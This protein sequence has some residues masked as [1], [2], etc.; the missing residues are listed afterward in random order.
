MIRFQKQKKIF[1]N[2][3]IAFF[4]F[5]ALI[6][7][8]FIVKEDSRNTKQIQ[9]HATIIA[10]NVWNLNH[11][12]IQAYLILALHADYYQ[13][14]KI[15][16]DQD[17]LFLE[18]SKPDST[19]F[20]AF[21]R[22]LHLIWNK[23]IEAAIIY[24]GE[25]IGVLKAEKIVRI[26]YTLVNIFVFQF[27]I[28]ITGIFILYLFHVRTLLEQQVHERTKK[29]HELVNLLPEMVLE[30]D[31]SGRILFANEIALSRFGIDEQDISH[32][33]CRDLIIVGEKDRQF[34]TFS[35]NDILDQNEYTAIKQNGVTFPVLIRSAPITSDKKVIGARVVIVDIT[36]RIALEEQLNRDQKMKSIGMMA[37]GVAHDLNNILSGL[38]NY[39]ELILMKLPRDSPLRKYVQP[40]KEAGIRAAAIV[41]DLLTVARG[42]AATRITA[43]TKS[44][45]TDY[46]ESP[47]FHRLL[48]TYPELQYST[49]FGQDP[50]FIACSEIHVRKCLMNLIANAA[51]SMAGKGTITINTQKKYMDE[52]LGRKLNLEEGSYVT[53]SITDQGP[54]IAP[55]DLEHIFEP[56]YTKKEMGKSGTG[57]G[58]TVVWN[59]MEDHNGGV[60]T[61]TGENGTTFT[62]YFPYAE[63]NDSTPDL[64][65]KENIVSLQGN[66]EM[67][68]VIDDEP[69]Q[70]DIACQLLTAFGYR[71][72]TVSSGEEAIEYMTNNRVDILLLDMVIGSGLSGRQTYEKILQLHPGQKAVIASGFSESEDVKATLRLGAGSLINKPYT[73]EQLAKE[74]YK[75]LHR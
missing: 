26:I 11:A 49:Q 44:L 16:L 65:E 21:L 42:V 59:T 53:I 73:K 60:E 12:G 37:G 24:K 30:T 14:F 63:E 66:G 71:V 54:G 52:D 75:E 10:D 58:L 25:V 15:T 72:E 5:Y 31:S 41:A 33:S 48:A 27:F 20:D 19:T 40:M 55:K 47:E 9:T 22:K 45:I 23:E 39:P 29:Y 32:F 17:E 1:L 6:G 51:E 57:L 64:V 28:T 34:W 8:L 36:E 38:V 61:T 67:V 3:I 18:V 7:Y 69:Q 35:S 74:I 43:E 50:V 2:G 62:L 70:R 46:L 68:L 13:H 4:A 56:F